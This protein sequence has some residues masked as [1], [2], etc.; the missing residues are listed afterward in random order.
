M[1]GTLTSALGNP[2]SP[3]QLTAAGFPIRLPIPG[4]S[5]DTHSAP[6]W[7]GKQL[8]VTEDLKSEG[9]T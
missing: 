7:R 4:A 9:E 3:F 6:V 2:S 1:F 8:S 5:L